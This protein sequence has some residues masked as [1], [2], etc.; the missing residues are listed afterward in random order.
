MRTP[1]IGGGQLE[2]EI[3]RALCELK[4]SVGAGAQGPQGEPGPQGPVGPQGPAGSGAPIKA[5]V[6]NLAAG[7]TALVT[8]GTPFLE[9]PKVVVTSQTANTDTSCT[10]SAH[11]VTLLGFTLRGAGNPAGD[12]AW[13]ATTAGNT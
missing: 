13:I 7:G 4:E 9:I 5:G 1:R 11:N 8:F 12:V 10:Y 2:A 3:W 6:V